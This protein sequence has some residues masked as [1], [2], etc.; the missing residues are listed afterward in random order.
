MLDILAS[1]HLP[2][3]RRLAEGRLLVAFDYDGCLAPLA[4][5]PQGAHMRPG[6]KRLLAALAERYPVAVVSGRAWKDAAAFVSGACATVVGNHGF[7]HGCAREVPRATVARVRRWVG[8]LE[9]AL[10]GVDGYF[11]E[12]KVSTLS[13]HYGLKRQWR[14]VEEAVHA[15]A[16]GLDGARLVHGKHVLN[17]VPASFPN[18]GD[19]V[20]RL[21]KETGSAQA[22][23]CGD[24]VTDEDVF[25]LG[26]PRVEGVRV[27]PGASKARWRLRSQ[28][29]MD[30]LLSTLLEL[31]APARAGRR[32]AGQR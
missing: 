5:T 27:G 12:D 31:R 28:E 4:R 15:A 3:L 13:I 20:R 29:D 10:E 25:A 18:K 19:A 14:R 9:A 26:P 24:D 32:A 1:R 17:C 30:A 23:F 22:I 2:E 11:I 7:E 6:T 21:L 16:A 8:A